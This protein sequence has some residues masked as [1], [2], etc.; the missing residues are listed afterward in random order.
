[1]LHKK[2]ALMLVLASLLII[3]ACSPADPAVPA[4][5]EPDGSTV[6]QPA[7]DQDEPAV[8][9]EESEA[10]SEPA[11]EDG[12]SEETTDE[13]AEEPAEDENNDAAEESSEEEA[14][15]PVASADLPALPPLPPSQGGGFGGGGG[16]LATSESTSIPVEGGDFEGD[17]GFEP[18]NPF[19]N[20]TFVLN[21]TLP[22][23]FSTATVW[24]QPAVYPSLDEAYAL[25]SE[26]GFQ[27]PLYQEALPPESRGQ[28][29]QL[30]EGVFRMP[31]YAIRNDEWLTLMSGGAFYEN[32]GMQDSFADEI[33]LPFDQASSLA[34]QQIA[35][36]GGLNFEYTITDQG[37]GNVMVQRLINGQPLDYPE[38]Y[39]Q[40]DNQGQLIF[41]S[42]NVLSDVAPLGD[43]PLIS[44]ET[45]WEQIQGGVIEN[46]VWVSYIFDPNMPVGE[47]AVMPVEPDVE[48]QF[49]QR[50]YEPGDDVRYVGYPQIY[51]AVQDDSLPLMLVDQYQVVGPAE[52][53]FDLVSNRP[54]QILIDGTI[55]A[56]GRTIEMRSWE[57][58]EDLEPLF[59]EG[60]LIQEDMGMVLE[61]FDGQTYMLLDV[62]EDVENGLEVY[63]FGWQ[64]TE[65][66]LFSFPVLDWIN[67]DKRIEFPEDEIIALPEPGVVDEYDPNIAEVQ[68]EEVS[69]GYIYVAQWPQF[70][71]SD[72]YVQPE[73]DMPEV[74]LQPFWQFT[75]TNDKGERMTFSVPAVDSAYFQE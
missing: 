59:L 35:A 49:W 23:D 43:Y 53:F 71:E 42:Y 62:P 12:V 46:N 37:F 29:E 36:W 56:D 40:F 15:E 25:A 61:T 19:E 63:V 44:P 64:A 24:Q 27:A 10:P 21:A 4:D 31:F 69:L 47:P 60:T 5:S 39:F 11:E 30:G 17:M 1:M 72:V 33:T 3:A 50:T 34:E 52:Q 58:A 45:A 73:Y 68:I 70:E 9:S 8:D 28:I 6:L 18:F 14:E 38:L 20:T 13:V 16:G 55:T 41:A 54:F 22:A 75:G 66:E 2:I 67:I 26:L 57:S 74:L 32:R 7:D 65:S 48:Y 51:L